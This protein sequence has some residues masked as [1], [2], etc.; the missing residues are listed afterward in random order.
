MKKII[1]I[2]LLSLFTSCTFTSN[3][4]IYNNSDYKIICDYKHNVSYLKY[5][6]Y[7][8]FGITV[9]LNSEGKPLKCG[10]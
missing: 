6:H 3:E 9:M 4:D 1:L 10:E 2:G 5:K 8:R 7:Y